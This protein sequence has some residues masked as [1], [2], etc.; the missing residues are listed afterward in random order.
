[1]NKNKKIIEETTNIKDVSDNK[2]IDISA[3]NS[4]LTHTKPETIFLEIKGFINPIFT[5]VK[6]FPTTVGRSPECDIVINDITVAPH[7]ITLDKSDNGIIVI[8]NHAS[9]HDNP[10]RV[11]NKILT[12][13]EK[14]E[15]DSCKISFGRINVLVHCYSPNLPKTI[16]LKPK[17]LTGLLSSPFIAIGL[18]IILF[19]IKVFGLKI[20]SIRIFEHQF[21][22]YLSWS[23]SFSIFVIYI[24]CINAIKS[25]FSLFFLTLSLL[26]ITLITYTE[27]P[28]IINCIEYALNINTEDLI[29]FA[30]FNLFCIGI[31]YL[32]IKNR[33]HTSRK[34][35]LLHAGLILLPIT[36]NLISNVILSNP[37][38][39]TNYVTVRVNASLEPYNYHLSKTMTIDE[40]FEDTRI[41]FKKQ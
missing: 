25:R 11:N 37:I 22:T 33:L 4:H 7:Q 24:I 39:N 26:S 35:T 23:M 16:Q 31:W 30:V 6:K 2:Q 1:M 18:V 40:Y 15:K 41:L 5:Q 38:F 20:S 28:F 13:Q 14:I 21:D 19:V 17:G 8:E 34:K 12:S 32:A 29:A 9:Q 3:Q 10:C 36:M 27:I